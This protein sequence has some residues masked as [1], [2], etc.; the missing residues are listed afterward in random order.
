MSAGILASGRFERIG[1][2]M[3]TEDAIPIATFFLCML[4]GFVYGW[5][6]RDILA[7]RER[8]RLEDLKTKMNA[9]WRS[10]IYD[11]ASAEDIASKLYQSVISEAPEILARHPEI[12]EAVAIRNGGAT[13]N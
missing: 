3:T 6:A 1:F 8:V 2:T 5:I 12:V 11:L 4:I 7:Q 10:A 13:V 9:G